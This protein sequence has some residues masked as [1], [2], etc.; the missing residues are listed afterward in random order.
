MKPTHRKT[1]TAMFVS[2]LMV[3]AYPVYAQGE[4]SIPEA[5]TAPTPV[6][7]PPQQS[8]SVSVSLPAIRSRARAWNVRDR[9]G[10]T[11]CVLVV[12][13][14]EIETEALLASMTDMTV[15]SRVF[16][17]KLATEHLIP[18]TSRLLARTYDPFQPFCSPHQQGTGAIYLQGYAAM[19]FVNI[20]FPLWT[21]VESPEKETAEGVDKLWEDTITEMYYPDQVN[22]RH[23]AEPERYDPQKVQELKE[24][25]IRTLKHAAN[26]RCM[27]SQE[28]LTVVVK[29]KSSGDVVKGSVSTRRG[30]QDDFWRYDALQ[31]LSKASAAADS[32]FL[33]IRAKKLDIDAFARGELAYEQFRQRTEVLIY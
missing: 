5:P 20:D 25:L 3:T 27:E 4:S 16:D 31:F 18:P 23:K 2:L 8:S 22:R 1:F 11:G 21:P 15:M 29:G 17:K 7:S 30:K 14:K 9:Y 24:T 6:V 26:I 33:S 12:P 10:P 13:N 32:T 28:W 19:F